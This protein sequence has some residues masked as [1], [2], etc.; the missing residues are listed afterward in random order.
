M[1]D[2]YAGGSLTAGLV[3]AGRPSRRITMDSDSQKDFRGGIG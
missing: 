3:K 1:A 2:V